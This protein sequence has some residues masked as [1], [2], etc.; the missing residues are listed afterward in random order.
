MMS[1]QIGWYGVVSEESGEMLASDVATDS[2]RTLPQS[3]AP[4]SSVFINNRRQQRRVN[5]KL[6][7]VSHKI[8]HHRREVSS[9]SLQRI[10]F[11]FTGRWWK[12]EVY[13]KK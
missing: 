4:S 6:A 7:T 13:S 11:K 1:V 3:Q 9:S 12:Y 8:D 2:S 5:E 10:I